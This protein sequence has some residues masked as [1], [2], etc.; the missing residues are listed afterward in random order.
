[1]KTKY[2]FLALLLSIVALPNLNAETIEE[3]IQHKAAQV[4]KLA[5]GYDD[6]VIGRKLTDEQKRLA[7]K[8]IAEKTIKGTYKFQN[9]DFFVIAG[10]KSD[11]HIR[12]VPHKLIRV[13]AVGSVVT[14][15]IAAP[16]VGMHASDVIICLLI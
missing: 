6:F 3:A 1:M 16:G 13:G 10:R 8:S 5:I 7:A 12:I 15:G 14:A 11:Q 2:L 4:S 9:G